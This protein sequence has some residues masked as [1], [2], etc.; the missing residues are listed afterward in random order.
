LGMQESDD[1][2]EVSNA[3]LQEFSGLGFEMRFSRIVVWDEAQETVEVWFTGGRSGMQPGKKVSFSDFLQLP[4]SR[5]GFEAWKKQHPYL[6]IERVGEELAEYFRERKEAG[7]YSDEEYQDEIQ[8][9]QD[10]PDLRYVTHLVFFSCGMIQLGTANSQLSEAELAVAK[11]FAD[12]FDLAYSRYLELQD[13]EQ[14]NR[15]LQEANQELIVEAA[16]ER[17]RG[18]AQ[19]MQESK[20]L[21]EVSRALSEEFKRLEIPHY[22]SAIVIEDEERDALEWWSI[23]GGTVTDRG[24]AIIKMAMDGG[25][26]MRRGSLKAHRETD[27]EMVKSSKAQERGESFY[28]YEESREE[29]IERRR[30]TYSLWTLPDGN[31]LSD[32]LDPAERWRDRR[33]RTIYY[34]IF[35][36]HGHLQLLTEE[37]LSDVDIAVAKRFSDLFG[38]AYGRYLELQ[39]KEARNRELEAANKAMSEA[40]KDLFQANQAL[41]RDSAVERIRGEVQAMEQA[42]DFERVL[43]LLSEDLKAV[44][45]SFDTCG[46]EVLDEPVDEPTLAHFEEHGYRYTAY[47][48][49]PNGT[50]ASNSYHI[51]APFR[52]VD[53]EILERFI[54]GEPW[55]A[56]IG[57]TN[58]ILE[59]P[60]SNY[61]RLR[62]T[63]SDRQDFT[64][65]DIESL[66]DFASAIALGY[67]RY[68]DIREIQTQTERKSAF[69]AS[70]SHELRTPM[71]A[72]MGFTRLVL[73][74]RSEN[75]TDRQRENLE[76]VTVSADHLLNLIN[77]IL[78]ISKI[79]SGKEEVIVETFDV[80]ELI[81]ACCST[82]DVDSVV[83]PGVKLKYEVDDNIGEAH[84]DGGRLRQI[85]INLLS[86]ALKFTE[87]GEVSVHT[88]KENGNLVIAV[89][90]TGTGIPADALDTIFEEF[91]QVEG[92]DPEHKG[93]GLGLPITKG[94]AEL[95]GGSI[96]VQSMEGKGSTFTVRVPMVY[97]EG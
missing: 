51:P 75:L 88:A 63:S 65:E 58:A 78:D 85:L 77:N 71:N 52:P 67:A 70:M 57:G 17:V 46:I 12:V 82:V 19:G 41:Q 93:T 43:S 80:K 21:W 91:R 18:K 45:L 29:W 22:R 83:T 64:E 61:G 14:R 6:V 47:T 15:E 84:T 34:H 76:K 26:P 74:R 30:R 36:D 62:I 35:N 5:T 79:E 24:Q 60:A 97:E 56:L 81:A 96:S 55:K 49:D 31:K 53:L 92:S 28:T 33:E 59:V 11:R 13:K 86:N 69:L 72:I 38:F 37:P 1:L 89:S 44:G 8:R 68:L 95:L 3:L 10:K 87:K 4:S 16:L 42:S 39:E 90:D 20:D 7:V 48:I 25:L 40:N 2:S 32:V 50:V 54:A 66:Q 9:M 27:L 73:G 23:I 94:F